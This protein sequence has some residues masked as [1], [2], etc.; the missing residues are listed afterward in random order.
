MINE[1]HHQLAAI[2]SSSIPEDFHVMHFA[3]VIAGVMN[4]EYGRHNYN[5]FITTLISNL[6]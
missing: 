4:S 1:R 5:E 2:I 3:E 6:K